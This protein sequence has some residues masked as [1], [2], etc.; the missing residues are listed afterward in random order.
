MIILLNMIVNVVRLHIDSCHHHHPTCSSL[1]CHYEIHLRLHMSETSEVKGKGR[2]ADMI[3][4][5]VSSNINC[6]RSGLW[7]IKNI[8]F[9]PYDWMF[10]SQRVQITL[11]GMCRQARTH[12]HTHTCCDRAAT[13]IST[14]TLIHIEVCTLKHRKKMK[15]EFKAFLLLI[16]NEERE[17]HFSHLKKKKKDILKTQV[18][19]GILS[20]THTLAWSWPMLVHIQP[21]NWPLKMVD[22]RVKGKACSW[23]RSPLLGQQRS[24][25]STRSVQVI[26]Q[27]SPTILFESQILHLSN[28]LCC[29]AACLRTLS[30]EIFYH[31]Y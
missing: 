30:L 14:L 25:R 17:C 18:S 3:K 7:K 6:P 22:R 10:E 9:S 2:W 20:I 24:K 19:L 29:I 4:L 5:V 12:T 21:V 16:W 15:I 26:F 8:Q 13:N 27:Q 31:V 23:S 28:W 1:C 11:S